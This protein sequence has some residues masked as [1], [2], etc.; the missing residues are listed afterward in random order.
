M[1]RR[2]SRPSTIDRLNPEIKELI[3]KLRIDFGWSIDE[4]LAKLRELGQG[5][6]SRSALGRHVK[7][8]EEIG[9]E[10]RHSREVANALVQQLGSA[11]EEKTA[12]LNI[13]LMHTMVF[14]LLTRPT[15][16][17]QPLIIDP[18]SAQ[19]LGRTL[20]SLATAKK[21]NAETIFRIRREARD[22]AL[23]EAR[24]KLEEAPADVLDPKA[25]E[26]AKR[27]MGYD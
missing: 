13:E 4:I 22:Q 27:W 23:A 18:E 1:T 9:A 20:S 26:R 7:S 10:L 24:K 16:D 12:D 5:E 25:L 14:R 15:D 2:R 17:G 3:G 6:I 21:L 11:P 8:L 19:Q